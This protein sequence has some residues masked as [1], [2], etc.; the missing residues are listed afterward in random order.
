[1]GETALDGK[2]VAG[3]MVKIMNVGQQLTHMALVFLPFPGQGEAYPER[4]GRGWGEG[5]SESE[6]IPF[7]HSHGMS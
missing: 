7:V 5:G 3:G 6:Y 1:M 4:S 2:H